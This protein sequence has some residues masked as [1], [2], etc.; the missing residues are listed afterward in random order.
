MIDYIDLSLIPGY[1]L[2]KCPSA[3]ETAE[4]RL[5]G[6]I[7]L[8][9]TV[10]HPIGGRKFRSV[11]G[12]TSVFIE[13]LE[14]YSTKFISKSYSY[15][16]LLYDLLIVFVST[17]F[18]R[19]HIS[20][21]ALDSHLHIGLFTLI[22]LFT[23]HYNLIP[24]YNGMEK[25]LPNAINSKHMHLL[26]LKYEEVLFNYANVVPGIRLLTTAESSKRTSFRGGSIDADYDTE[27]YYSKYNA[28]CG[29]DVRNL[30]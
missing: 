25:R 4:Q 24:K 19:R 28:N 13:I 29:Q 9:S 23:L 10:K 7:C 5:W 20:L 12:S 15:Q 27:H 6:S 2:H 26:Y 18:S 16:I 22:M 21:I 3:F 8:I 14:L 17:C 11:Y 1:F 30:S